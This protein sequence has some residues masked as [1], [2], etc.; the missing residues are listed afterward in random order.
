MSKLAAGFL[1]LLTVTLCNTTT[2]YLTTGIA[3][4]G[5]VGQ[6]SAAQNVTECQEDA[7]SSLVENFFAVTFTGID[8]ADPTFNGIWVFIGL[9]LT[10]LGVLLMLQSWVPLLGN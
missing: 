5:D 4:A 3:E 7:Q 9:S 10:A 1:I 6:C 8:G 2:A